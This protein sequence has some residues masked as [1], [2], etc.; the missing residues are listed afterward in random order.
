MALAG[1][2]LAT[3]EVMGSEMDCDATFIV[4]GNVLTGTILTMGNKVEILDG[5]AEGDHFKCA[6]KV[7]TPMGKMKIKL[8]GDVKG[9]DLEFTLRNPMGKATF[10]GKR[11]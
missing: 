6:C 1:H 7:P 8:E 2:Y 10:V 3:G 5:V 9:D 4:E 11:V